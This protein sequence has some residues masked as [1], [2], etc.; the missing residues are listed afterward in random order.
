[1]H[2]FRKLSDSFDMECIN[3]SHDG[4]GGQY[5]VQTVLY[6]YSVQCTLCSPLHTCGP[7]FHHPQSAGLSTAGYFPSQTFVINTN[8]KLQ[9]AHTGFSSSI[10]LLLYEN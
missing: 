2:N 7:Q 10:S 9:A 3:D 5:R 4:V 6:M 8:I 1:M